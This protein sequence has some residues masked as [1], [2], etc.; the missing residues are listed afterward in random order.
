MAVS[1]SRAWLMAARPQTLPAAVAPVIVGCGVAIALEVFTPAIAAAAL[2]GAVLIQ[3]GTNLA[4]DYYDA[5]RGADTPDREGFTRVTATGLIAP[6]AVRRAMLAC[7][8]LSM[9][10]GVILVYVGGWPIVIIGLASI[11]AGIGY[12]GGPYPLGY[13]GLGD[14]FVFVFFGLVA[15]TGTVYVQAVAPLAGSMPIVPPSGTIPPIAIVAG[16]PVGALATAVLVINNIRDRREDAVTGKRTLAVRLGRGFAV[17]E[18]A[19]LVVGAYVVVLAVALWPP[20]SPVVALPLLSLP[21]A[22]RL[23][24]TVRKGTDGAVLNPALEAM[25]RLLAAFSVL[26]AVGLAVGGG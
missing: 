4:N 22:L 10:V 2:G 3:I 25:G 23:I 18:F 8:G 20:A 11:A 5:R 15:V 9:L 26:L 1:R 24:G 21:W 6:T 16:V 17:A 14:V 19:G 13:H 7:F 12:T